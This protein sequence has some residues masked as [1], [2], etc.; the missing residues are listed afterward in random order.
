MIFI[1]HENKTF[2]SMLGNLSDHFG[3]YASLTYNNTNGDGR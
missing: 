1:L 3:P 2:D